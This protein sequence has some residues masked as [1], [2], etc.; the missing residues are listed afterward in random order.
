MQICADKD[1]R[2]VL[3]FTPVRVHLLLDFAGGSS[4]LICVNLRLSLDFYLCSFVSIRGLSSASRLRNAEL[5][6]VLL[7]EEDL[8]FSVYKSGSG[9]RGND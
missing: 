8:A 6:R 7:I 5:K 4:N 1:Q 2:F 3:F 9:D